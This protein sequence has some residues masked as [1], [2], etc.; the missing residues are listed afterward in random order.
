M[1]IAYIFSYF[2]NNNTVSIPDCARISK[3]AENV[4][5]SK[6]SGLM[7]QT[8]CGFG[9]IISIDFKDEGNEIIDPV[10]FSFADHGYILT[11]VKTDSD[12]A[13]LTEDYSSI[14]SDMANAASFFG[15]KVLREVDEAEFYANIPMLRK[16]A[17][18]RAVLRAAHFFNE[19]RKV[20]MMISQLK[21]N[22]MKSYLRT[23]KES[24]DSSYKYLQNV[25]SPSV[26][27]DQATS[28]AIMMT[29]N[30]LAGCSSTGQY[31]GACRIH[32]GGFAGTIQAYIPADC[33]TDYKAYIESVFG[34]NS[35]SA[36][37]IRNISGGFTCRIQF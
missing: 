26:P 36:L 34:K 5:F 25:Y 30:F 11:V 24:G 9:G 29:E 32:G 2:F 28:I 7:D 23:V 10:N 19:N 27:Q 13:D 33:F 6:P 12:H 15:K 14:T 35:A 21:K 4:Y 18:G 17:G 22:C 37:K 3:Y 1:L 31:T 8:S 16:K 20:D